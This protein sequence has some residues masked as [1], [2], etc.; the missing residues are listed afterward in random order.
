M[1][2]DDI[3][4]PV[5]LITG[6]LE[7]GKTSFI[8]KTVRQDYFQIPQAT[9]IISTEEGEEEYDSADLTKYR[10]FVQDIE[11]EEE[12]TY[13]KLCEFERDVHPGRVLL[14]LNPLWGVRKAEELKL[15]E[16]WGIVQEIV[17][18][19]AVTY[20]VYRVN[21]KSLFTEMFA[22][23]D[24]VI[25]NRCKEDMQLSDFRR[26]IKVTN[27][28][29]ELA[30]EG[31]DGEMIDLFQDTLPYDMDA[32][33]INIED[34]DYG[35]FYVDMQDDPEKYEGKTVHFR[36]KVKKPSGLGSK[37]FALGWSAMTCCADDVQFIG[38]I[39]ASPDAPK[40]AEGDWVEITAKVEIRHLMAYRGKGPV[41]RVQEISRCEAPES[42]LVYFN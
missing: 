39:C 3:R 4:V 2:E 31:T 1:E 34:C 33:V 20:P 22:N 37:R 14:E 41:F 16:G 18:V 28:A 27:P 10:T 11:S 32:D 30:F 5:Y 13:E 35:I 23:T 26:G 7:S 36:G 25:F 38:Y 12:F 19:D 29:C 8:N 24:L 6:F 17:N 9:L 21:M 42:D 40:Y 15:P